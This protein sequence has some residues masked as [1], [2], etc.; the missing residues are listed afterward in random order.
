MPQDE[1]DFFGL[2]HEID[3]HEH[4]AEARAKRIAT[5]ACELRASIATREPL[6]TP[7]PANPAAKRSLSRSNSA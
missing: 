4:G 7:C 2:Q 3:G 5:K 1:G 6:V